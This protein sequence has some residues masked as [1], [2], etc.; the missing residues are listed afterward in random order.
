MKELTRDQFLEKWRRNLQ[1]SSLP[2]NEIEKFILDD[3]F[4]LSHSWEVFKRSMQLL[5]QFP[6]SETN[7]ID[8]IVIEQIS[9]FHDIGKFFQE[10]HTADNPVIG[11][12]VYSQYADEVRINP[13]IREKVDDGIRYH[14]FYNRDI[15]PHLRS[16]KFIEGEIVRAADKMLDNLVEKVDRYWNYGKQRGVEFFNERLSIQDRLGFN[17]S[18]E[19]NVRTDE[20][21]YLLTLLALKPEDFNHP[22]LQAAYREWCAKPKLD[23]VER[24]LFLAQEEGYDSQKIKQVIERYL[25]ERKIQL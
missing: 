22:V 1:T 2:Q 17:F 19:Y 12:Q 7:G 13:Q 10:I 18:P 20:L 24:I 14:D 11:Q 16:P 3:K 4:G 6:E 15:D 5:D 23:V 25:N 21:T 8:V 9:V